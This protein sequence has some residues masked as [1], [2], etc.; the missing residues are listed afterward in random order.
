MSEVPLEDAARPGNAIVS[1][2]QLGSCLPRR[3]RPRYDDRTVRAPR[4][5][6]ARCDTSSL[7]EL[8]VAFDQRAGLGHARR[9]LGA[10][11]GEE[12]AICIRMVD[13]R[14]PISTRMVDVRLY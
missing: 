4:R 13:V 10:P 6:A 2:V 12:R 8:L 7:S 9:C 1:L 5:R 11:R 14:L 3:P